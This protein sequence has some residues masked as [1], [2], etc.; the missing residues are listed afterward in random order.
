MVTLNVNYVLRA[1]CSCLRS[2]LA[3]EIYV[4]VILIEEKLSFSKIHAYLC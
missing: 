3:T 2:P 1:T 4:T